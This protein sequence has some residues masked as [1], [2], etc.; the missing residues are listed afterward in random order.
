[1]GLGQLGRLWREEERE[2]GDCV[3]AAEHGAFEPVRLAVQG[4]ESRDDDRRAQRAELQGAEDQ[5]QGMTEQGAE[6]DEYGGYEK[7]DLQRGTQRDGHR[8]LHVVLVGDLDAHDVLGDV[9]N[10]WYQDNA[11]KQF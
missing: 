2:C 4:D 11:N 6:E 7:G 8:E 10:Y 5:V 1:M 3:E 9:A